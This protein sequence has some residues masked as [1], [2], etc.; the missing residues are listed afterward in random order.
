SSL[1]ITENEIHRARECYKKGIAG[2]LGLMNAWIKFSQRECQI[3]IVD[4]QIRRHRRQTRQQQQTE[5][6]DTK[7]LVILRLF[8]A[9][10]PSESNTILSY[11][12][13]SLNRS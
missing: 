11:L 5:D 10:S 1:R 9:L 7:C 6:H 12:R 8:H 13:S 2:G 3:H 4:G